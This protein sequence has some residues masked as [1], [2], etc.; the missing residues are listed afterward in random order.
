MDM[1][2]AAS[3]TAST[4]PE[5]CGLHLLPVQASLKRQPCELLPSLR[6]FLPPETPKI[7]TGIDWPGK[8]EKRGLRADGTVDKLYPLSGQRRQN[9]KQ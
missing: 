8:T 3:C 2:V 6:V 5:S 9:Q 7:C 4:S 1:Y